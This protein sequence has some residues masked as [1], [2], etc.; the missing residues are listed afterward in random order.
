LSTLSRGLGWSRERIEV[1]IAQARNDLRDPNIHA[2]A[3]C[4]VV[5]GRK[6]VA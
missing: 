6:P 1:M 4:Y 2:Y 5:Y 3:E